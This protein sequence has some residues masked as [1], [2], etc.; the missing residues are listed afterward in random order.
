M[1]YYSTRG[2]DKRLT[3]G[4]AIFKGIADDGGLYVPESFPDISNELPRLCKLD[5]REL[6]DE[7][8]RLYLTDYTADELTESINRA[9]DDKFDTA[10]IAPLTEKA[11]YY[12]LELFH[13]KTLAFK[14]MALSL[15]PGLMKIAALKQDMNKDLVVL[16]ATSGDTGKAALEGFAGTEDIDIVVFFPLEGVSEIQK[17]QMQTQEGGNTHV[18]GV[19][20]NFDDAQTGVKRIFGEGIPGVHISSANSIN[21]GRLLPQ[22]VYYVY[23]YAQMVNKYGL[24][25]YDPVNF[26]VPTGNFG[27]ILAGY[28][29]KRMGLPI[30]KLICA[31]NDNKVL[32]DFLQTHEYD[33][34]RKLIT[35]ASPSMDILVSSNLERLLFHMSGSLQ[36]KE[37]MNQLSE[38]GVYKFVGATDGFAAE[39][40]NQDECFEGIRELYELSGYII[41]THT[42][43]AYRAYQKYRNNSGDNTPNII[44]S[45]ASPFKFPESVCASID[46]KHS[47][48]DAFE[49]VKE[50]QRLSG[51]YL[52]EQIASLE[53][54]EKRHMAVCKPEDMKNAILEALSNSR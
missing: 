8:L 47:G 18:I 26:T 35:S 49:S 28:Y 29:A 32:Y 39:Y 34:N 10:D 11:G 3:S 41:D 36:T 4:A 45:T 42:A 43:V 15:L 16:T 1:L 30:N 20:G 54:K 51:G 19:Y 50:L 21:I 13:G 53:H 12:F 14:D 7:I 23:A 24:K 9:Y 48:L 5:Y 44:L 27:N 33:K 31:S 2:D 52:P 17:L 6:A 25:L 40:A 22:I 37:Y 38:L 46:S